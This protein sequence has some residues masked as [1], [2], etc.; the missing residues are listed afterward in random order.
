MEKNLAGDRKQIEGKLEYDCFSWEAL[1][2]VAKTFKEAKRKYGNNDSWRLSG[3]ESIKVYQNALQRHLIELHKGMPDTY[4]ETINGVDYHWRHSAQIIWNAL[5]L[6]D[7]L[8]LK[9]KE[10][11]GK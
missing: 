6:C 11:K 3:T 9:E 8:L 5:A 1:E 4:T 2:E 7:K 10:E